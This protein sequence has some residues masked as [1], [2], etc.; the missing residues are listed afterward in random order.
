MTRDDSVRINDLFAANSR[1]LTPAPARHAVHVLYAP[2]SHDPEVTEL[3]ASVLSD[4]ELQRAD[5]LVAEG[6]KALFEQRRAFRRFCGALVLGSSR[7]LSQIVFNETEKGRPYLTDL[8]DHW[9]S[10][11]SCRIG[12]VG[13]GRRRMGSV[14][15]SKIKRGTWRLPSS[16]SSSFR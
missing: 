11:S 12:F 4:T 15:T 3:C 5:R 14:S 6:D 16:L 8:P 2:V 1:D 7:P 9:F 13:R 10:F